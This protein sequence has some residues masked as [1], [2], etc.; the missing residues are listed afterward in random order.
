MTPRQPGS[1]TSFARQRA[2]HTPRDPFYGTGA[3]VR[4]RRAVLARDEHLCVLHRQKGQL[5]AANEVDHIIPRR[6]A[7]EREY[8]MT[9]LQSLCRGCHSRK[10]IEDMRRGGWGRWNI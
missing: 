5:V 6:R 8:D 4:L 1:R 2:K 3:W 7:P 9:N 10:T